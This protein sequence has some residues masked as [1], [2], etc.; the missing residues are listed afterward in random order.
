M[1]RKKRR[2]FKVKH[3]EAAGRGIGE[4]SYTTNRNRIERREEKRREGGGGG[5][6]EGSCTTKERKIG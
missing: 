3:E 4:G 2:L 1:G 6:G 5:G